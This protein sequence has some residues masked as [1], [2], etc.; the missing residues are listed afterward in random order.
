[1]DDEQLLAELSDAAFKKMS[2]VDDDLSRM[3]E[4]FKTIALVYS[5]QGIIDNGGLRY[6]FENDWPHKPPYSEFAD[7]YERIGRADLAN[8][9][10]SA[11]ASF[12]IE[13]PELHRDKRRDY[14]EENYDE[15]T[16]GVRGWDDRICG[17]AQV[18]KDLAAWARAHRRAGR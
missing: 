17:D 15:T 12:P 4:P 11:A 10:R 1:M 5:A 8:A 16:F 7:A 13:R 3:E 14:I 6:F 18:W 2:E 9:L